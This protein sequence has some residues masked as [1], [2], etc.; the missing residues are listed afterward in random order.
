MDD[1]GFEYDDDSDWEYLDSDVD[2]L[3]WFVLSNDNVLISNVL[4]SNDEWESNLYGFGDE[5]GSDIDI[6]MREIIGRLYVI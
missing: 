1:L 5:I 6:L 3:D 2:F 4:D